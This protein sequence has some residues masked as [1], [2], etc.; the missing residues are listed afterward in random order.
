MQILIRA[1][2]ACRPDPYLL[3]DTVFNQAAGVADW[4]IASG[5]PLNIGG[6]AAQ[7]GLE[8][9][10]TIALF[11][12]KALPPTHPLAYLVT[13]GDFRGWWGDAFARTDLGEGPLGSWLWV[14]ERAPL[15]PEIARYAQQFA[16]DALAPLQ[17]Q[18]A[19]VRIAASA[20][21]SGQ[22]LL[23]AVQLY[24]RDGAKVYDRQ[25]D[26]LWQQLQAG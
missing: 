24:G 25:F 2:E 26:L 3:W 1:N 19:V 7:A 5:E 10:V 18:G 8:T 4:A 11:T 12:D 21:I 20:T 22:S 13:D 6:L 16:L 23:L 9:A 17:Q 15:T 14:L